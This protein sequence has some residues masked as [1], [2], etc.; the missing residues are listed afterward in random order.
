LKP[1][2]L[3]ARTAFRPRGARLSVRQAAGA[4]GRSTSERVASAVFSA[5]AVFAKAAGRANRAACAQRQ[6]LP[7]LHAYPR[8]HAETAHAACTAP[9]VQVSVKPSASPSLGSGVTPRPFV[10]PMDFYAVCSRP[11]WSLVRL[12]QRANERAIAPIRCGVRTVFAWR[13]SARARRV[14]HPKTPA[15]RGLRARLAERAPP[16]S[17]SAVVSHAIPFGGVKPASAVG[18]AMGRTE[19]AW[20]RADALPFSRTAQS[21]VAPIRRVNARSPRAA[22]RDAARCAI[23]PPASSPCASR[24]FAASFGSVA[25]VGSAPAILPLR[26]RCVFALRCRVRTRKR[27]TNDVEFFSRSRGAYVTP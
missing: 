13:P 9:T 14:A 1:R 5:K 25:G 26:T 12:V 22:S 7:G 17:L 27:I 23:S 16:S 18:R 24:W 11:A 15:D 10:V 19:S 8:R 20:P 21:A 2:L 3:P 6:F 4:E